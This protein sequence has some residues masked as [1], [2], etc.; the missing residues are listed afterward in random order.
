MDTNNSQLLRQEIKKSLTDD[1][2]V[3]QLTTA[4]TL[5]AMTDVLQADV[6]R[7][8]ETLIAIDKLNAFY[9]L[10][11]G[12]PLDEV[13]EA[14]S[15]AQDALT[16]LI[17][18]SRDPFVFASGNIKKIG[19]ALSEPAEKYVNAVADY[20]LTTLSANQEA[21]CLGK[22]DEV[23]ACVQVTC[24][25]HADEQLDAAAY[26]QLMRFLGERLSVHDNEANA[27][28]EHVISYI[29][30][31]TSVPPKLD[32][33]APYRKEIVRCI[34]RL[35]SLLRQH[36]RLEHGHKIEGQRESLSVLL[37]GN[38]VVGVFPNVRHITPLANQ[39]VPPLLPARRSWLGSLRPTRPAIRKAINVVGFTM[40]FALLAMMSLNIRNGFVEMARDF[41]TRLLN[42]EQHAT[43][44]R[45]HDEKLT[46]MPNDES[47]RILTRQELKS[48]QDRLV[49]QE[50]AVRDARAQIT[51][52]QSLVDELTRQ[53]AVMRKTDAVHANAINGGA[54]LI[55]QWNAKSAELERQLRTLGGQL[56]PLATS[57]TA[58]QQV[59]G[60]LDRRMGTVERRGDAVSAAL[61][62]DMQRNLAAFSPTLVKLEAEVQQLRSA[63][64]SQS[65]KPSL[66]STL[67]QFADLRSLVERYAQEHTTRVAQMSYL[68]QKSRER[69][70]FWYEWL[71]KSRELHNDSSYSTRR[72]SYSNY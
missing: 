70:L 56:V 27:I 14:K 47:I 35:P 21:R 13:N 43:V 17:L 46:R 69:E 2:K 22:R 58:T 12:K 38:Y 66:E 34:E 28:R 20:C 37:L 59:L 9:D 65:G 25:T 42:V 31:S 50:V 15:K 61:R 24:Y 4:P 1:F 67:S 55:N 64:Y 54:R 71:A 57:Q 49:V 52:L 3:R 26:P 5:E 33:A 60:N 40:V 41:Q 23:G 68:L 16:A 6:A 30:K 19:E 29:P 32:G 39:D 7:Q 11:R 53:Q 63:V 45:Q 36:L 8:R 18:K 10:Q 48:F 44:L 51:R 62:A 72:A